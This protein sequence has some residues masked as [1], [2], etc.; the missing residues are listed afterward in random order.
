MANGRYLGRLLL[1]DDDDQITK[2]YETFLTA[3]GFVVDT[4]QDLRKMKELL[5]QLYFDAVILDLQ[6]GLEDGLSGLPFILKNAPSTKVFILTSHGSI[7]KAVDAMRRGATGFLTKG[8]DPSAI[9]TELSSQLASSMAR[10]P[11]ALD[12]DSLRSLGLVGESTA[13]RETIAMIDKIRN[14]DSTVLI[15][16]ESGTG[17]E[18]VARAIHAT[19]P[20][21]SER[22]NAINCGA[23]PEQL[24]ESEL[25]GH[26]KG[27]FTDAKA[28]RK[29]IF[30]V[31][32]AGTLLLDEIGDMPMPLQTKL[33]RV[34]QEKQITPIGSSTT[35][36]INTRVIA[37]THRDILDEAKS[38][39]FREDL[40][41]RLSVVVIRIPP[42]RH[43]TEDIPILTNHFLEQF[44]QRFEKE[45]RPPKNTLMA[46]LLA[47]DWPGNVREL[48]NAI[49]RAV[50]LSTDG[51]LNI[52][53]MFQHLSLKSSTYGGDDSGLSAGVFS[54]PLTEAKQAFEKTYLE[55]LLKLSGGNISEAARISGRYRADIYRLMN[56]YGFDKSQFR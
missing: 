19:S 39:R 54:M 44:N 29:G 46:R 35:I 2:F 22:F 1:V 43:R 6:L 32:S 11:L 49:E 5:S 9:V 24:L 51:E 33:L 55:H 30:E 31:C 40:Y 53:D 21:A 4:C 38:K 20:R 3:A 48:Q 42:L 18:V 47:Y 15:L 50:V 26:K 8:T 36:N 13:I 10:K 37:A 17:K 52:D 34:L 56:R 27:S 28:D 12:S 45:V 7:E 25:F 16:G 23:I 41:Y 14:V